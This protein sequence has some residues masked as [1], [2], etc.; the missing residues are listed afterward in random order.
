M[1]AARK[2]HLSAAPDP[3]AVLRQE[4]TAICQ[5]IDRRYGNRAGTAE[6]AVYFYWWP[7]SE[8]TSV[9]VLTNLHRDAVSFLVKA[10]EREREELAPWP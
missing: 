4:I 10:I 9:E 6:K 7:P 3:A 2:R 8:S 1:T 5:Q